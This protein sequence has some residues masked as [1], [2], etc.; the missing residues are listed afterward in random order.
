MPSRQLSL[1]HG[2]ELPGI[3]TLAKKLV[4]THNTVAKAYSELEHERLLERRHGLRSLRIGQA[5]HKGARRE[6]SA[7]SPA[8]EATFVDD[9]QGMEIATFLLLRSAKAG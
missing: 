5:R 7:R 4:V 2:D 1:Q 9:A 8:I 6:S 3:R